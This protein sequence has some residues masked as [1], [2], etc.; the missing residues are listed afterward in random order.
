MRR[1]ASVAVTGFLFALC[2]ATGAAGQQDAAVVTVQPTR[3]CESLRSVSLANTTIDSAFVEPGNDTIPRHCRVVAIV[4]HPPAQDRVKVWV[5]LPLSGWNARFVGTGGGGFSGGNP[6]NGRPFVGRGFVTAAT[7]TGHPGGSA[8]FAL[9]ASGRLNWMLIR[10]NAY[11]GIHEMT[12]TGKAIA[13]AFFGSD[14]QYSYFSGCSTGGRQGLVEAWRYPRD[15][16]G[17][18]SAAPAIRFERIPLGIVYGQVLM[19]ESNNWVPSCKFAAANAAAV[20]ACDALDGVEDGVLD[21]PRRCDFDPA[22]LVGTAAGDCG[23]ITAMD[24]EIVRKIWDGARRRDGSVLWF[25]QPRGAPFAGAMTSGTP[26]AGQFF[27]IT[28]NLVRYLLAQDPQWD[29]RTLTH[30]T[31]EQF[32]AQAEEEYAAVYRG[33]D[34]DL[35]AFRDRGGKLLLWHGWADEQIYGENTIEYYGRLQDEMGGPEAT[36]AFARLFMAPG[37]THCRGGD[38]P[39]PADP[40][41]ALVDWVEHGKAPATLL[42]ERRDAGGNVVRSRPLCMYPMVARYRGRGSTDDAAN[43]ACSK[44]P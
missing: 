35:R 7:D 26:L 28:L 37:V 43:F 12:V 44:V 33:D 24:A 30:E 32:W 13:R 31:Y 8:S 10:D 11:L 4:T 23:T 5:A 22:G 40:F 3:T 21:D 39:Q 34:P 14:P 41:G 17:I 16:D 15:Y 1:R 20:A 2:G 25:S 36:A 18:L 38:G 42:A 19:L 6:A 27:P 29:W 9:D